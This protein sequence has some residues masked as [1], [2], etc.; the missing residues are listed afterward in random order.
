MDEILEELAFVEEFVTND[1]ESPCVKVWKKYLGDI[2]DNNILVQELVNS[3][4]EYRNLV[5]AAAATAPD[6]NAWVDHVLNV[7]QTAQRTDAWYAQTLNVLTASE[8]W[9]ICKSSAR[10]RALLVMS[11]VP[12]QEQRRRNNQLCVASEFMSAFDWGIR[13]EPIV[14]QL[15]EYRRSVVV[16]E[17]GRIIHRDDPRIAASPDGVV[18]GKNPRLIEIKCPV[19]REIGDK[20]PPEYFAQMQTQMEVTGSSSCDYVEVRIRSAY[21][22]GVIPLEGP[23]VAS[24]IIWRV[25]GD[26][27]RESYV[28]GPISYMSSVANI[29]ADV[30]CAETDIV[31]ETIHWDL[32]EWN[33]VHV[34][35][36]KQW[37]ANMVPHID[38][39]WNDVATAR[40]GDFV[41]PESKRRKTVV[42]EPA[43]MIQ[44]PVPAAQ[45]E[46]K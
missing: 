24:G 19:T 5:I 42:P 15:Y 6:D 8:I 25:L 38:A 10:E 16:K 31:L 32:M 37:W 33:E 1:V 45:Q 11:K 21:K 7:P 35:R 34:P 26:D 3:W 39:F 29:N 18:I 20:I 40:A 13:F 22:N 4:I 36:D 17:V 44:F 23:A 12:T 43:C 2:Y 28:Y 41:V 30:C 9:T 14:K 46:P 27:D